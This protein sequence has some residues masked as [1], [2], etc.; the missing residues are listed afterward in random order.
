MTIS[1]LLRYTGLPALLLALFPQLRAAEEVFTEVPGRCVRIADMDLT[2]FYPEG[3]DPQNLPYSPALK[4]R[5]KVSGPGEELKESKLSFSSNGTLFRASFRI[6]ADDDLY[7]T[8]ETT[9][10][11]RRNGQT[12]K[13]WNTDNCFYQ[14]DSGKRLYQSHPWVLGVRRDG[15]SFGL[16]FDSTWRAELSCEGGITLTSYGAPFPVYLIERSSPQEVLAC[17]ARLIGTMPLPPRWTLGYHQA[18]W[19]YASAER[20]REI[21]DTFRRKKIPCDTIWM[22]IDYMDRYEIFTFNKST[23][24]DPKGLNRYLHE[25]GFKSVWITDPGIKIDPGYSAYESGTAGDHWVKGS[26]GEI[27]KAKVW[28]GLCVFPD[29]TRKQTRAWWAGQIRD[30]MASGADGIWNDM[31]EPAIFDVYDKSMPLHAWHR[32]DDTVPAGPHL[33]YRNAYGLFMSQATRDGMVAAHPDKR[34]FVLT[35]ASFLGGQR[36][37]ATWTGDNEATSEHMRLSIPM[38][39]NLGLSGQ[40]F[41]GPDLGGFGRNATPELWSQWVGFGVFFPFC[42]GHGAADFNMKEPWAFGTDVENTARMALERRYRL[43]PFLY[44]LF[45]QASVSGLPVMRP[46]FMVDPSDPKLRREEQIF[47]LGGNLLVIPAWAQN[48]AL[49]N[50]V[51]REISLVPNDTGSRDQAQLLLREGSLLPLGRVV[52]NTT[53]DSLA[54]LTLLVCPDKDGNAEG[55]LYEDDGESLAYERGEYLLSS[56]SIHVREG[57]A[58]VRR[59]GA[60]GRYRPPARSLLVE[61]VD[62]QGQHNVPNTL[63]P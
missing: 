8:G 15:S 16:L 1:R 22:D 13:L 55:S 37:A 6:S 51:W 43:L 41:S 7:G 42:R 38:T 27:Y 47:T 56:Y 62:N 45:R 58:E 21:A 5:L 29:F 39:L 25:Q 60:E 3:L 12:I 63:F 14:A 17:L 30:F 24:P 9:G 20:V 61:V 28:P 32:G 36:Y 18:R 44:T 54:P 23:F 50:G 35:R 19:S 52:Q 59:V 48:P 26:E 46:V 49:P 4:Q 33:R 11:L 57:R 31:N 40:P 2:L 10:P 53:E 34:P